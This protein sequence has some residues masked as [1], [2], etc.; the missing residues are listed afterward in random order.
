MCRSPW[1]QRQTATGWN[2]TLLF[3]HQTTL[4]CLRPVKTMKEAP[5]LVRL[6]LGHYEPQL[7]VII[8]SVGRLTPPRGRRGYSLCATVAT[9]KDPAQR[10]NKNSVCFNNAADVHILAKKASIVWY[11]PFSGGSW[12]RAASGRCQIWPGLLFKMQSAA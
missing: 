11:D 1:C 10:E 6:H 2:K 8:T 9:R 5:I 7:T 4:G 3:L 12:V